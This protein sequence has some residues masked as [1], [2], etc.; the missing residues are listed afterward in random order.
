[1]VKEP[2]ALSDRIYPKVHD[3]LTAMENKQLR[4]AQ[5]PF[6]ASDLLAL[7]VDPEHH[8]ALTKAYDLCEPSGHTQHLWVGR[9]IA[10]EY[11][12][13]AAY[14]RFMWHAINAAHAFYVPYRA[15]ASK[16]FPAVVRTEA[17]D[18]LVHHWDQTADDMVGI[19][20]RFSRVHKALSQLNR[21][22]V[23]STLPQLRY[24]WPCIVPLL[25]KAGFDAHADSVAEPNMRAGGIAN[26]SPATGALAAE[27]NQ[28]V[29]AHQLIDDIPTPGELPIP[30][31]IP[32]NTFKRS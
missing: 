17:P 21:P 6:K 3:A 25:R 13:G 14:F 9:E 15:G 8:E 2:R 7:F 22:D 24:H 28:T 5:Y 18:D 23:C 10:R 29:A 31:E 16:D 19:K 4:L 20:Y 30:Y 27:T 1:M 32:E 11:G 12:G 26:I